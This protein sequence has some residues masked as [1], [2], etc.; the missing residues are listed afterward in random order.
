MIVRPMT[1]KLRCAM[2]ITAI[3]LCF[4]GCAAQ[5][6]AGA[7]DDAQGGSTLTDVDARIR[8]VPQ[9]ERRTPS[10]SMRDFRPTQPAGI[11]VDAGGQRLI[12]ATQAGMVLAYD[13]TDGETLW[14]FDLGEYPSAPPVIVGDR[15]LIGS[16]TEELICLS[17]RDGEELWR[18]TLD[19]VVHGRSVVVDDHV[20]VT[21]A[22]EALAKLNLSTGEIAWRFRR[23]RIA[24][25][26]IRGGGTPLVDGD[27]VYVGFSD[28]SLYKLNTAGE[29]VWAADLSEGSRRLVDVDEQPLLV[30]DLVIAI[31]Q[32]G[33]MMALR[34][35]TGARVWRLEG[36]GH[37]RPLLHDGA[38][39]TTT[40]AGEIRW[41]DPLTGTLRGELEM[42][43]VGLS[44]LVHW[45]PPAALVT[46]RNRGLFAV[47]LRRP[48]IYTEVLAQ[49]GIS[50]QIAWHGDRVYFM[51][52]RGML[53]ALRA[54]RDYDD[55]P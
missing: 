45:A 41:V 10:E 18:T 21:T 30:G 5:S 8:F 48:W 52:N 40:A 26:E 12:A 39:I 31:S 34:A 42:D 19:A 3:A 46:D 22:E 29:L 14:R 17:L 51:S 37:T 6:T 27:D 32:S 11:A 16:S 9:W 47:D 1:R 55:T 38:L 7:E 49:G 44:R 15:V 54:F 23:Q 20:Y 35:D 25:L 28:G 36:N 24:E 33:G 2:A 13:T 43:T 50:G 4:S 53:H